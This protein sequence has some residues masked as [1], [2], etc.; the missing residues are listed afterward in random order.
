MNSL[1]LVFA[2]QLVWISLVVLLHN[3]WDGN[4]HSQ[5]FFDLIEIIRH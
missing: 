4:H 5:I 2:L 1:R 3:L